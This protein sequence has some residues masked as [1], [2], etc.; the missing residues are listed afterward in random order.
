MPR[1][2]KDIWWVGSPTRPADEPNVRLYPMAKFQTRQ[3]LCPS[4]SFDVP[5]RKLSGSPSHAATVAPSRVLRST[6]RPKDQHPPN[7]TCHE[8]QRS[9]PTLKQ[10]DEKRMKA[11][12][13]SSVESEQAF[14]ALVERT[15]LWL[16]FTV[17]SLVSTYLSFIELHKCLLETVEKSLAWIYTHDAVAIDKEKW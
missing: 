11:E 6:S 16:D 14:T 5:Q 13:N 17:L 1:K 7:L 4:S 3:G 2:G 12:M 9:L 10:I 8:S 15:L